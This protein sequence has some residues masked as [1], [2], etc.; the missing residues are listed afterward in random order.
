[1]T[2]ISS[3]DAG[4]ARA[5]D[6]AQR[7]RQQSE[8][9]DAPRTDG[10]RDAGPTRKEGE[11]AER[12]LL[13]HSGRGVL[14]PLGGDPRSGTTV[15]IHGINAS[16]ADVAPLARGVRGAASTFAYDD[17]KRSLDSSATD[18]AN[19]LRP[20]LAKS[21]NAPLTINAHS[22]GGRV[23]VVALDQLRSEGALRGKDVRLN[24]IAP[25]LT[26]S[27]AAN[28]MPSFVPQMVPSLRSSKDMGSASA[29]QKKVENANLDGVRVH[30]YGG[31][32]DKVA[33]PN[34]AWRSIA[35][36]LVGDAGDRAISVV[37]ADHNGIVDAVADRVTASRPRAR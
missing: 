15:A 16:P 27:R 30:V 1:M 13:V 12:D 3:G 9:V 5:A 11:R 29:F 8:R 34:D 36:R 37:R 4:H 17:R 23:A 10:A 25:P 6:A 19:S 20:V 2:N 14:V 22:M 28:S 31:A 35:R 32:H 21:G 24:L 7:I 26:G 18:L 33:P